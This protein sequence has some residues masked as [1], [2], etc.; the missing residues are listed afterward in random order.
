MIDLFFS[1]SKFVL[2][3][4]L[5]YY[6]LAVRIYH[7][8]AIPMYNKVSSFDSSLIQEGHLLDSVSDDIE[9]FM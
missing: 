6:I 7:P 3:L 8:N 2:G 5:A 4:G 1:M 9:N